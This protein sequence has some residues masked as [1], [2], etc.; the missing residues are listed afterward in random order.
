MKYEAVK[1][2]VFLK[3][4][5][6]HV[7]RT[8]ANLTSV[9]TLVYGYLL[10]LARKQGKA[11][12]TAI[13]SSLRLDRQSTKR[14]LDRLKSHLLADE[15]GGQWCAVEPGV[16]TIF[17]QIPDAK[18]EWWDRFI[19]DRVYIAR[20]SE[21]LPLRANLLFWHLVRMA[22][23]VQGMPGYMRLGG[24]GNKFYTHTYWATALGC[25]RKTAGASISRLENLKLI[26]LH[27]Y[28]LGYAVGIFP[29]KKNAALWRDDWQDKPKVAKALTANELFAVPSPATVKQEPSLFTAVVKRLRG[30]RI[31]GDLGMEITALIIDN[32]ITPDVW[33]PMLQKAQADN[34]ANREAG[35]TQ[36]QHCGFLFRHVLQ[37]WIQARESCLRIP[38]RSADDM[39]L[40]KALGTLGLDGKDSELLST[41]IYSNHLCVDGGA[42]IPCELDTTNVAEMALAAKG[43]K[44]AFKKMIVAFLCG[45]DERE[46]R[47]VSWI[48]RW[49]SDQND[50]EE[51]NSALEAVGIPALYHADIRQWA[52]WC[53]TRK[54]GLGKG[55]VVGQINMVLKVAC[56][57]T[58]SR[59]SWKART[60]VPTR[61]A[62]VCGL[63]A[64]PSADGDRITQPDDDQ[65]GE[66]N[67]RSREIGQ[68]WL[69]ISK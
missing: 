9:D 21:R 14:S 22:D 62:E 47:R 16:G 43:D 50:P 37:D 63:L 19:Y 28:H 68:Q 13:C 30:Y 7:A 45:A 10:F 23:E 11:S 18:G 57:Q 48:R 20:S 31:T 33:I 42:T 5:V 61:I 35:K 34:Y 36:N 1:E 26:N 55:Q 56:W 8:A 12:Q 25:D 52:Y 24:Y 67:A 49:E 38:I 44:Q 17:Q 65:S 27:P 51:D 6:F 40:D 29:L 58:R 2:K 46:A 64:S 53:L 69:A 54:D 66:V 39:R 60:E 32:D 59:D 3:V 41:A 4:P 15:R